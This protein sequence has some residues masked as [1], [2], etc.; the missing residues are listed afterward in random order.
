MIYTLHK[1]KGKITVCWGVGRIFTQVKCLKFTRFHFS[2]NAKKG[3]EKSSVAVQIDARIQ[4]SNFHLTF[5]GEERCVTGHTTAARET[6][7]WPTVDLSLYGFLPGSHGEFVSVTNPRRNGLTEMKDR[8]RPRNWARPIACP[9]LCR[10][11]HSR[12]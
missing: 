11:L 12:L 7:C 4:S 5:C 3:C 10:N 8:E 2:V 9:T 6:I 1:C